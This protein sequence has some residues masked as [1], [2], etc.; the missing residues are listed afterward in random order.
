MSE[1]TDL[2]DSYM[3]LSNF[4]AS[5]DDKRREYEWK[6]SFG[7]WTLI[8]G[9]ILNKPKLPVLQDPCAAVVSI[10]LGVIFALT[11]IRGIYVANEKDKEA[12]KFYWKRAEN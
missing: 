9:A 6:I 5:R 7:F 3:K 11:W 10:I 8:V 4:F 2:F 12:S 1:K